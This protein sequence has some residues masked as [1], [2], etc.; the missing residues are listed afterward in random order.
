MAQ[1]VMSREHDWT[2]DDIDALPD[3]GLQ[4][5]LLDGLLLV[6][7]APIVAHQR[8]L[9]RLLIQLAESCPPHLEVFPAPLDWRPDLRTSLQPDVLIARS[10][11]L[12]VKNITAPL[13]L[14]VEVL[15]PS[16]RR[17]DLVLKRSKYEEAGVESYWA[18][19][20]AAPSIVAWELV[21]G[22]YA[23]AGSATG[24]ETLTLHRP[25][26]VTLIPSALH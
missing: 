22:R 16:T 8:A 26:P 17:K 7:P 10:D 9:T 19:D 3:D 4:Y 2:V 24:S 18:V 15:S 6:T 25:F 13:V 23:D 11:Q 12:E 5:E 20:P 21:D 14:A 1:P